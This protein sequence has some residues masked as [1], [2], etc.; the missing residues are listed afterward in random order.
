MP[1]LLD[2]DICIM[3]FKGNHS[4]PEKINSVGIE[5]CY[6]S[7]ITIYELTFGAL[8][9]ERVEKHSNEVVLLEELYSVLPAYGAKDFY[10][11][12]KVRLRRKGTLI[13]DFDLLI[14]CSAVV[15]NL[16]MVTNNEKHLGRI[17]GISIENWTNSKH[18]EFI[19]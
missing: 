1:Y 16:T 9:S 19:R 8:N 17:E 5:N 18:N 14:G 12:E 13:P 7:E 2:S 4:I 10:A 15:N 11:A 6:V 3:F